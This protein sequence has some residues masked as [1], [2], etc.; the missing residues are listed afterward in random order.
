[1]NN[2]V[3]FTGGPG[4]GK[5][6]VIKFLE[7]LGYPSAI[8]VGRKVIQMQTE[9]DGAALPWKDKVAFRDAMVLE[10]L[11]NYKVHD[12]SVLT[13]FDRS[14]IDSYG[15]SQLEQIAISEI[16]L[17]SCHELTYHRKVFIFPPWETIYENDIERKQD[18]NEAVATYHEMVKAY[19]RF[20]YEL[21]EVPKVSVGDRAE[22]ILDTVGNG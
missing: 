18:F 4:S 16:L 20:G 13:F 7:Q 17:R 15:Y 1:M 12:N 19:E 6:S 11:N 21:I 14:I 22:F 2:R 5:T 8:E 3:V 9:R 10:E